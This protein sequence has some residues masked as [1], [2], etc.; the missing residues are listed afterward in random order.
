MGVD[1]TRTIRSGGGGGLSLMFLVL[2][3]TFPSVEGGGDRPLQ[4]GGKGGNWGGGGRVLR[5]L[6]LLPIGGSLLLFYL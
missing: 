1:R 5:S 6:S 2:Y 4:W 3:C